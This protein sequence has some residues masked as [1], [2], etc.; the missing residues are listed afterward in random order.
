MKSSRHTGQGHIG[1]V[2]LTQLIKEFQLVQ[3]EPPCSPVEVHDVR[4][5]AYA[6]S[7]CVAASPLQHQLPGIGE[8][9]EEGLVPRLE[10]TLMGLSIEQQLGLLLLPGGGFVCC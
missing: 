7:D 3:V 10:E 5:L 6:V 8:Q 4:V 2:N 1:W 9:Q